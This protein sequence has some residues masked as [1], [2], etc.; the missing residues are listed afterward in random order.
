MQEKDGVQMDALPNELLAIIVGHMPCWVIS[1]RVAQVCW[2]WRSLVSNARVIGKGSG[3]CICG[4]NKRNRAAWCTAAASAGHLVCLQQASTRLGLSW[5]C[6][7]FVRALEGGHIECALFLYM[8][9]DYLKRYKSP[10]IARTVKRAIKRSPHSLTFLTDSRVM[11]DFRF[12]YL[13][14]VAARHGRLDL[15]KTTDSQSHP[16]TQKER[17]HKLTHI[18]ASNGHL[19]CLEWLHAHGC[20]VNQWALWAA[21]RHGHAECLRFIHTSAG[22]DVDARTMHLAAY[23]GHV[24]CV[25]YLAP[26]YDALDDTTFGVLVSRVIDK[27]HHALTHLLLD[28]PGRRQVC[29]TVCAHKT[30]ESRHGEC[31]RALLCAAP[32][33]PRWVAYETL[34]NCAVNGHFDCFC[35]IYEHA[36]SLADTNTLGWA[37]IMWTMVRYGRLDMLRFMRPK[38]GRWEAYAAYGA[39]QYGRVDILVYLVNEG[40]VFEDRRAAWLAAREGHLDVLSFLRN[41]RAFSLGADSFWAAKLTLAAAKAG[42]TECLHYIITKMG[43]RPSGSEIECAVGGGHLT[44]VRYAVEVLGQPITD[45]LCGFAVRSKHMRCHDWLLHEGKRIER[46]R[47]RA[48]FNIDQ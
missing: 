37:R 40:C 44:T 4:E 26:F 21:A 7:T 19:D 32:S 29:C 12:H 28:M 2:R 20:T 35:A 1:G 47:P 22:M 14:R 38:V 18:A 10:T 5:G 23:N 8:Q 27:G 3:L 43:A 45:D 9:C 31:L 15:L 36:C 48:P 42:R 17:S 16:W 33:A 25:E 46:E 41:K 11:D 34:V 24:H 6:N 13:A 39:A 30:I